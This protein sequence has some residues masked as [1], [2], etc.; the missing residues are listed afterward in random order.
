LSRI[1]DDL[2]VT[3]FEFERSADFSSFVEIPLDLDS[4]FWDQ[5]ENPVLMASP[6]A[7]AALSLP[8]NPFYL[9]LWPLLLIVLLLRRCIQ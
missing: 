9:F 7:S 5:L 2:N 3:D 6:A 8:A 1:L 4:A